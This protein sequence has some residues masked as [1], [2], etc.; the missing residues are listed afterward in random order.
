MPTLEELLQGKDPEQL[1]L[2]L[3]SAS[4]TPAP[5]EA[6]L[7][8]DPLVQA[9]TDQP[10]PV[11]ADMLG[12]QVGPNS[13]QLPDYLQR[14]PKPEMMGPPESLASPQPN[15]PNR[16]LEAHVKLSALRSG[17][18]R[19]PSSEPVDSGFTN[20]TVANLQA[21]QDALNKEKTLN[22]AF[23]NLNQFSAGLLGGK[24]A[25]LKPNQEHFDEADKIAEGKLSQFKER[26]EK[27]KEDP[28]SQYSK[29]FKSFVSPLLKNLGMNPDMVKGS[30]AKQIQEILPFAQKMFDAQENREMRKDLMRM[31]ESERREK[32]EEE[33]TA[34]QKA[35]DKVYVKDYNDWTTR[36]A[37]IAEKNLQR[38]EEARNLLEKDN[39]Y[40]GRFEGRFPDF[41]R[42]EKSIR[43]R[44]DVQ[45]AAQAALKATLGSQF[46]EK[47]GERIMNMAYDEKLS[48]KE[49]IKKIDKAIQEIETNKKNQISKASHFEK[50]G[51]LSG[52][53]NSEGLSGMQTPK[54]KTAAPGSIVVVKGKRYK[55]G[56]DGDSLEEIK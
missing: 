8:Q 30:S 56:S 32:K 16:L 52:Y 23:R 20:N 21:E 43:L 12:L 7:V 34:G 6:E 19:T 37:P 27:E 17:G 45:A 48:P 15:S 26:T 42:S 1:K 18:G 5:P 25:V 40:S 28:N 54:K 51:T 38:L 2:L 13:T 49:N 53:S 29:Q 47:E 31:K 22:N 55:V 9:P 4:K 24:N 35:L 11:S 3:R 44:Q 14:T 41:L 39:D 50:H 36:D 10:N 46:T 33:Q